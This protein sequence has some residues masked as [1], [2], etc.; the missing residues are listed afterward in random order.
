MDL[1]EELMAERDIRKL[2]ALSAQ[3]SDD[4]N[5]DGWV[6]LFADNGVFVTGP[7]RL[8]GHAALAAF[9]EKVLRGPKMRHMLTNASITIESP[10]TA[11]AQLDNLLLMAEDGHWKVASA[12]RYHDKLVKT[13]A[14]W[15]LLER[16]IV[17]YVP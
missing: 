1:L 4:G 15:K 9:M 6:S 12:P 13:V 5:V 14:G 2:L 17:R 3:H 11:T 7:K 10:T 8:E 16:V